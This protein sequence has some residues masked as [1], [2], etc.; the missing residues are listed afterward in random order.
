M[1]RNI[2]VS[3]E[4]LR[5]LL[6]EHA[7]LSAWYYEHLAALRAAGATAEAPEDAA[8][9]AFVEHLAHDFPE[10]AQVARTIRVP[11]AYVP[12][13]PPGNLYHQALSFEEPATL[14]EPAPARARSAHPGPDGGDPSNPPLKAAP[15]KPGSE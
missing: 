5:K 12:P 3:E 4:T 14:I 15:L 6:E 13:P 1:G 9:A 8:R 2:V 11:P 7:S 10:V